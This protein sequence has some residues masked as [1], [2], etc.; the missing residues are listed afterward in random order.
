[1]F[2]RIPLVFPEFFMIHLT[3]RRFT[4]TAIQ[5]VPGSTAI[6]LPVKFGSS[7]LTDSQQCRNWRRAST[8]IS[9]KTVL[10]ENG[11]GV[12]TDTDRE[13]M[14]HYGTFLA[15]FQ[16]RTVPECTQNNWSVFFRTQYSHPKYF[17]RSL[18]IELCQRFWNWSCLVTVN[19]ENK[20][21]N[22]NYSFRGWKCF[23]IET[24]LRWYLYVGRFTDTNW[25]RKLTAASIQMVREY[26]KSLD[27][28]KLHHRHS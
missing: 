5:D 20:Q 12:W 10:C 27:I 3:D 2:T 17:Q 23:Q 28:I 16:L 11:E 13:I 8:N 24:F 25:H 18:E 22:I 6:M 19:K 26:H 4:S 15:E 7:N 21:Y 14:G 1:M 9:V